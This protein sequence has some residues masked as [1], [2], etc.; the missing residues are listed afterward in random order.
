MNQLALNFS[1]RKNPLSQTQGAN[2]RRVRSGIAP[3]ILEFF[4][5]RKVGDKFHNSD[6]WQ[7]I[8]TEKNHRCAPGS[9][10][11]IMRD[12]AQAGVIDYVVISRSESLYEI[13]KLPQATEGDSQ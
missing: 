1:N 3:F 5:A 4:A 7:F 13:T 12:L 2:L 8:V 6:L 9:P 10:D 11:R